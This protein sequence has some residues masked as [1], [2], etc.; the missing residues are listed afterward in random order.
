MILRRTTQP[1]LVCSAHCSHCANQT[2][3]LQ[4]ARLAAPCPCAPGTQPA[5]CKLL[6]SPC[7][8][9]PGVRP[10]HLHLFATLQR[11]LRTPAGSGLGLLHS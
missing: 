6:Q 9:T 1:L 8:A 3:S 7:N 2:V 4:H 10:Q 11:L 5:R